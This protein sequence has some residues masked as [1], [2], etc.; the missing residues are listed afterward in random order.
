MANSTYSESAAAQRARQKRLSHVVILIGS[1]FV[2]MGVPYGGPDPTGDFKNTQRSSSE[3]HFTSDS[4]LEG[5][6]PAAYVTSTEDSSFV[7][8]Q[9][10]IGEFFL[11]Q[12]PNHS[13]PNGINEEWSAQPGLLQDQ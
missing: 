10:L 3:T 9:K 8:H 11:G 5:N 7:P 1:V 6:S 2:L 4:Q 13:D 12:G